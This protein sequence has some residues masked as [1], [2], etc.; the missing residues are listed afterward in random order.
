MA[1][2]RLVYLFVLL[3]TAGQVSYGQKT[4]VNFNGYSG[5]FSFRGKGATANSW[6]NF[7]PYV[8]PNK[9][10]SNPYG[11]RSAISYAVEL[12]VQRVTKNNNIFGSGMSFETLTSKVNIDTVTQNGF[13]Y[14]Q[15]P[16]SGKTTL[17]NTFITVNPFFGH[18]YTVGKRTFDLL[19]GV[20]AAFCLKSREQGSGTTK[21]NGSTT[22]DNNRAKP[23][24]DFRPRVQFAMKLN[25]FNLLA[26]Y[27][28]GL[29]NYQD[30]YHSNAYTR[31]LRVGV[32]YQL[33]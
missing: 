3:F 2:K 1:F 8:N 33:K 24:I 16:A 13:V 12:Q 14:W 15:Y 19:A 31:F 30:K 23:V 9:Y 25:R 27:S 11:K 29:T 21:N 18:R 7:N 20:D 5:L 6:I 10:T 28:M 26:G 17:K 4:E 22:V 32:G